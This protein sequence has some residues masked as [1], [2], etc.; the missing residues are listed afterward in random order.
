MGRHVFLSCSSSIE[1]LHQYTVY[2]SLAINYCEFPHLLQNFASFGITDPH[3]LQFLVVS[4]VSPPLL[5]L[6]GRSI[7]ISTGLKVGASCSAGCGAGIVYSLP[8]LPALPTNPLIPKSACGV[9]EE[10]AIPPVGFF[11]DE[12]FSIADFIS[13]ITRIA[14]K[15][16]AD[17]ATKYSPILE[18]YSFSL[19]FPCLYSCVESI[20]DSYRS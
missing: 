2:C 12:P 18:K 4:V 15:F 20:N 17:V 19:T 14:R 5:A 1:D 7:T 6:P 8:S 3:L 11:N 9:A 10:E 13:K 16:N